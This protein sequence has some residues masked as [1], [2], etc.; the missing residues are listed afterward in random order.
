MGAVSVTLEWSLV[1]LIASATVWVLIVQSIGLLRSMPRD[2]FLPMQMRL[3]RI[4]IGATAWLA[5]TLFV[6]VLVRVGISRALLPAL[7]VVTGAIVASRWAVPRALRAGGEALRSEGETP[8]TTT[9]FLTDGGGSAT[10]IWHRV[11]LLCVALIVAGIGWHAHQLLEPESGHEH[12][13]MAFT[14]QRPTTAE[15]VQ[16]DAGTAANLAA[17][18]RAAASLLATDAAHGAREVRAAWDRVFAECR[19]EGEA[20]DRLHKFLLPLEPQIRRT[21]SPS[22]TERAAAARSLLA[23]LGMFDTR[24]VVESGA[25]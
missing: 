17:L 23:A 11:V 16:V 20:H 15:R 24:F 19:M 13:H 5:T 2:R 22:A 9:E 4:W 14:E 18:E 7:A 10:R 6:G 12:G 21:E 8:L 1:A 25:K 3:V